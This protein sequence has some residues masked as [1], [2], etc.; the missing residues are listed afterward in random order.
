MTDYTYKLDLK[1]RD[2]E[3][4]MQG[5]VNNAIYQNYLEHCRHEFLRSMGIDF[6]QLTQNKVFLVVV[7][8]ELD[9][10]TPLHSGDVFWIGLNLERISPIRFVFLQ[11]IFR[12]LDQRL[13]LS[14]RTMGTALNEKGR[15]FLPQELANLF[16]SPKNSCH[17]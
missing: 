1:V 10:K 17:T 15:P 13:I 3:C 14:A 7:R 4:D 5:I 9:Y 2:Y 11:D 16:N 8:S 12:A 6:N